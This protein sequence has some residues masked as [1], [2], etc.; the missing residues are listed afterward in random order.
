MNLNPA[1]IM[2]RINIFKWISRRS[3]A[4][5]WRVAV[6]L[7]ATLVLLGCNKDQKLDSAPEPK[8]EGEKILMPKNSPA[9]TSLTTEP[10][11]LHKS[12]VVRLNG[13][14][15]WD[16]DIT[17]R[18][19]SPFGGRVASV[20]VE[21]GQ[22]I[23]PGDSLAA[24]ASPDF[25]QAQTDARRAATDLLQAERNFNRV[26]ELFEHGAAPQKDLQS[27]EADFE[28]AKSEQERTGARLALYSGSSG[29]IGQLYQ[30][31]SPLA[32]VVVEKNINPGQEVRP[33][34][35]LANAPQLFAPLFVVSD[36]SRLWIQIDAN[37]ADLPNLKPGQKFVL[38][39]RAFPGREFS[40][41]IKVVS[42]SLDPT[43]RT[44]KVRGSVDN[45]SRMLKAEMFV[46][47][48][49]PGVEKSGVV[50]SAGAVF[51]RGEKHYLYTEEN[52]GE[53][54][55]REVTAGPDHE[56][57]VLII[58]GLDAGQRVVTD[59]S[60]LLEQLLQSATGS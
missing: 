31:A 33:D 8:V 20:L 57:K 35:M 48:A 38:T 5:T 21:S 45:S 14:L 46:N 22:T 25:G 58:D 56:G 43:T 47:V 27:A 9:L 37:E 4:G 28:R 42:D 16:D 60:L 49:L 40:G 34:Q 1:P 19:F 24:I 52:P 7:A 23:K 17:V 13:R 39:A 6:S 50:V 12:A 32:G 15:V 55:R 36:P 51:L 59:G 11:E 54:L 53:F 3:T 2:I 41:Q 18:V 29:A 26:R 10:A 30:L 44:I